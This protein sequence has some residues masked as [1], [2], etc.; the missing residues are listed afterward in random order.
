MCAPPPRTV[1]DQTAL[2]RALARGHLQ[3]LATDHCPFALSDKGAGRDFTEIPG[4][5]PGIEARLSLAY[6]KGVI[7]GRLSLMQW[8]SACCTAPA[9]L[10]GLQRKGH[11]APGFDA[12]IVVFDPSEQTTL[13]V[14]TLHESVDWSAYEGMPL[15]GWPRATVSRGEVIVDGGRFL[16]R[17]GRGRFV[18]RRLR[19]SDRSL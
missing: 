3:V 5:L 17:P 7:G 6:T 19:A 13:S 8:V 16:G 15:T 10:A 11:I 4:G 14:A 18:P 12:D 9:R 1:A 2:W